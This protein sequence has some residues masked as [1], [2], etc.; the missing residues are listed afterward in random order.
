MVKLTAQAA[1]TPWPIRLGE[2]LTAFGNLSLALLLALLTGRLMELSGVLVT[3]E[4]PRDVGMVILAAL[5]S[6]LVLFL[7]LLVFL[8]PL[9]LACRMILRG[10]NADVRV[11]GGLGSLVLIGAV[12]L[13]SY[14]LFSRVPLGSDLFGYSL[15]D[16]LTTAR[17]GYHFT[18]LS[19]ATL[20]LPLAVF[21]VALR[22]FN[23]HPVL[24]ARAALLLLGIAVTLSVSGVRPLPAR[25][26]L[27][28]EFAYNVAANKAAL[29]IA[30]TIAHLRR[31]LPVTRRV[32]DTAQQ[33][34]YLDPQYPFL[35][36]EDTHDVLGE[37]FNFE[38]GAP[39]P[40]IVFLGV[41][42]WGGPSA[43]PTPTSA[44]SHPFWMS[45]L[46]RVCTS[47]TSLRRRAAR[48]HHSPRSWDRCPSQSR[49]STA[50]AEACRSR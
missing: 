25:G 37:Y 42:D 13:S 36:G 34:R 29:F 48:S 1:G 41:E 9:F 23:R 28:S 19:V 14:F 10:K 24:K 46:A 6:D 2:R 3:T 44:A 5:R 47:K 17:G 16:I 11:Y 32:P 7:E 33:F 26:A 50:S 45:W 20:L 35:R 38:P 8:L 49:A 4:V 12:A 31:P 15:G 27:R 43:A 39:P 30:E 40:N 21:L 22:I 18:E